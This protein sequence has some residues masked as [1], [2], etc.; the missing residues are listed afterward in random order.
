MDAFYLASAGTGFTFLCTALGAAFVYVLGSSKKKIFTQLSLGFSGGIMIAASVF[1]LLLPSIDEARNAGDGLWPACGGFAL[2]VAFLIALDRLLPHIHMMAKSPEGV[3]TSWGRQTLLERRE[4]GGHAA[5]VEHAHDD[6]DEERTPERIH[7]VA[8]HAESRAAHRVAFVPERVCGH[9]EET[10]HDEDQQ[11][12]T[13]QRRTR[14]IG[15]VR[16]FSADNGQQREHDEQLKD[17]GGHLA[18]GD[19]DAVVDENRAEA[20]DA[21]LEAPAERGDEREQAANERLGTQ[22]RE[23]RSADEGART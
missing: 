6:P 16:R 19:A 5:K 9:R 7:A 2:G 13:R 11:S 17:A 14:E 23:A 15:D 1:G 4:V 18:N 22:G 10:R 3:H 21:P 20:G 8:R 12:R